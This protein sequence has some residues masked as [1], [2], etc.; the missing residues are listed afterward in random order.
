MDSPI[1]NQTLEN[2]L[3]VLSIDIGGSHVKA[4]VLNSNGSTKEEYEKVDTPYPANPEGIIKAIKF[5]VKNFK[6]YDRIS[7]GFPGYV[8]DGI[9]K[10][11]P[12]LGTPY[13]KEFNLRERLQK[14]LG[15]PTLVVNDADL[16]GL[17]LVDGIG[18]EMVITLG[19]GFGTALL[20]DGILLPHLELAHHPITKKHTYDKYVGEI[21]LQTEGEEKWNKRMQ[22]VFHN[23]KTVFNYD[24][25]YISGGNGSKLDFPLD[26]NMKLVSNVDGIKGGLRLWIAPPLKSAVPEFQGSLEIIPEKK[27]AIKADKKAPK[28]PKKLLKTSKNK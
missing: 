23:L 3:Q 8:K 26:P 13:W 27:K 7:V 11:A 18:F 6:S 2:N 10:T 16:Q 19:T 9:V 14:E 20:K 4:T 25:L 12:N 28:S 21:A 15:K 5:L 1:P 17:G 24:K 22:K